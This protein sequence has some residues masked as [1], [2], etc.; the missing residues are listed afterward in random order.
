MTNVSM[1]A[2]CLLEQKRPNGFQN[3]V[4]QNNGHSRV[5]VMVGNVRIFVFLIYL[6]A[7]T[8]SG[9]DME[10]WIVFSAVVSGD[11]R[12]IRRGSMK[13]KF[14][15]ICSIFRSYFQTLNPDD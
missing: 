11:S 15:V 9:F 6:R 14:L 2:G 8:S 13:F 1:F 12:E 10:A 7:K 3:M 5:G 4:I